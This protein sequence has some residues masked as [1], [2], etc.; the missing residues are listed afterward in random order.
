[1]LKV[2]GLPVQPL[3]EGITVTVPIVGSTVLLVAVNEPML[4]VPF[5]ASPIVVFEFIQL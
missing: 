4:P 1:M 5:A 3:A 2:N